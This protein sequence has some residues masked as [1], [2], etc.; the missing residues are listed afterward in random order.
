MEKLIHA[1]REAAMSD[2]QLEEAWDD[3][4]KTWAMHALSN[5]RGDLLRHALS[6]SEAM[7]NFMEK[8]KGGD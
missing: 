5:F 1:V 6:V 7:V 8:Y 2:V 4:A 3:A